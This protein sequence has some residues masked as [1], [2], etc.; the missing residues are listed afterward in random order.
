MSYLFPILLIPIK[1]EIF[2]FWYFSLA[3]PATGLPMDYSNEVGGDYGGN[4]WGNY[5]GD[6]GGNYGGNYGAAEALRGDSFIAKPQD[7]E[8]AY[9]F[10]CSLNWVFPIF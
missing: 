6:Y 8:P 2:H 7:I 9:S 1:N 3:G 5:V 4:Y 10:P